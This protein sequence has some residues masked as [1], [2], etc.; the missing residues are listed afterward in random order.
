MMIVDRNASSV[1]I[2][3]VAERI[4][5]EERMEQKLEPIPTS[6]SDARPGPP[7]R[8]AVPG[9]PPILRFA[10]R[11]TAP[12][13]PRPGALR[14]PVKRAITHHILANHELQ[15]LEVMAFV[16]LAFPDAPTEFR[17]GLLPIMADEQRHTRMHVERAAELG[18]RF[19]DLPVNDYIWAKAQKFASVLDYLAGLPLTFEGRNLDHTLEF[20]QY[21]EQ[22]GD[23]RSA[24]VMRVIHR[25]EIGH[26]RFGLEWLRRLK[27]DDQSDWE[28]Y[29]AHLHWPLRAEK[30]IG[31]VFHPEPRLRAGMSQEFLDRLAAE[32]ALSKEPKARGPNSKIDDI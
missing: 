18:L 32:V 27:P 14:D 2:R 17:R 1:E 28:A 19:G 31:D 30:S 13:M 16:L 20:E 6:L 24:A 8:A 22:A 26:V 25:E 3:Q 11:R 9:R 23:P 29:I 12:A 21:F 7:L 4:L 5:L 10:A 15:A